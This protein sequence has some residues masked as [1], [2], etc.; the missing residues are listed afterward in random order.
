MPTD[1]NAK[2]RCPNNDADIH[3]H[4]TCQNSN[5]R[6]CED[7]CVLCPALRRLFA[8]R[9]QLLCADSSTVGAKRFRW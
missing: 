7:A 9:Q 1:M 4:N 5:V 2:E 8:V 6:F 3:H